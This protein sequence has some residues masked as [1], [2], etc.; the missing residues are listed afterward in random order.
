MATAPRRIHAGPVADRSLSAAALAEADGPACNPSHVSAISRRQLLQWAGSV[1][2]AA[3]LPW[4]SALDAQQ[5]FRFIVVNDLHHG[6]SECDPF[7]ASLVRQMGSHG[8][9]DFCIIA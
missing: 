3:A 4:Q 1:G 5:G 6:S 7:F 2:M 8:P 9:V